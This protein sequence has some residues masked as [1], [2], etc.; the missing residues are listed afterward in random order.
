MT[1]RTTAARRRALSAACAATLGLSLSL[2]ASVASAHAG[3]R[4]AIQAQMQDDGAQ[5]RVEVNAVDAAVALGLG[6]S[7]QADELTPH[8]AL[9]SSWLGRGLRVEGDAGPCSATA[10]APVLEGAGADATVV[11]PL[12]YACP[13][14]M[15]TVVLHDDTIFDDDPDHET[16]VSI[17][18][19]E[20]W[21]AHVLRADSR[22]LALG[23]T[24]R[25]TDTAA[26]F[27][28]EGARHLVTGYD[29]MLFLLSLILAAGLLVRRE[30]LRTA[31]RD[32]AWVVTAF[33]LGHSLSLAAAALGWV[34]LPTRAVE[35]AIAA[36]IVLVALGNVVRPRA[37]VA[38]PWLAAAFGLIHGFG[39]SSVLA[40]LGLPAG[41]RVIALL[42]FNVGIELAQLAFVIAVL[43]P[44][45][46]LARYRGYQ[47]YV[48]Q[49]ASL[50]IATC[51]GLWLVERSLGS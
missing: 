14:P 45:A 27:V 42:S 2:T 29:H 34:V 20:G 23:G 5:L 13:Q 35:I 43:L 12:H 21:D 46:S 38:R 32:V 28:V 6:T 1:S 4:S 15:G 44:L 19:G 3:S 24:V 25:A 22:S 41:H 8:A 17:R 7:V 40:E 18:D 49:G 31:M 36:S 26:A 30:G 47:R 33:T 37:S 11:V 16:Y 9:I 10:A 39:V 50:A 48:L 51:G